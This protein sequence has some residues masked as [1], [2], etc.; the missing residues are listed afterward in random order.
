MKKKKGNSIA[1]M[2]VV[3]APFFCLMCGLYLCFQSTGFNVD[4]VSSKLAYNQEWEIPAPSREERDQ[5]IHE[6]FPQT[7]YYLGSG[8][9]CY[10]FISEDRQY[11][12][13]FFKMQNLSSAG[14]MRS[15]PFN[16]MDRLRSRSRHDNQLLFERVFASYLDAYSSLKAETGLLYVHLNKTTDLKAKVALIGVDGKKH[17]IDLDATEFVVQRRAEKIFDRLSALK[18]YE[19]GEEA[20]QLIRSFFQLIASRAQKGFTDPKLS[21]RNNFGFVGTQAVQFDCGTLARD[22][23]MKYP[24]NFRKEILFVAERFDEWA[25][26]NMPEMS[27]LI[28]QEAQAV[29]NHSF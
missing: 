27:M 26:S 13:K 14:G 9:Q 16:L 15:F 25:Q 3:S 2:L 4:K 6:I 7:Y 12:L 28:Q 18:G 20:K 23:S 21:I 11:V 1:L 17:L 29:I 10:A 5:L 22:S 8:G 19:H 24:Y